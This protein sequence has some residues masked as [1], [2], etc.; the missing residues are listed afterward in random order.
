MNRKILVAILF[1]L[2]LAVTISG[3][4]APS[5]NENPTPTPAASVTPAPPENANP[6]DIPMPSDTA[7]ENDVP[8]LPL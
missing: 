8:E 7:G 3:C 4:T 6:A 1:G 5:N 2:L